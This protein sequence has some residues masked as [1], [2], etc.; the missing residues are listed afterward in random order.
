MRILDYYPIALPYVLLSSECISSTNPSAYYPLLSLLTD[1]TRLPS[2]GL[3][4][5]ESTYSFALQTAVDAG[6]L[7]AHARGLVEANMAL[8][9]AAPRIE[10]FYQ[11]Y[12]SLYGGGKGMA[13]K[14]G[15]ESW[16]EWY[17]EVLCGYDE[18]VRAV[19]HE[20]IEGG[21][22]SAQ[23]SYVVWSDMGEVV[24]TEH[25]NGRRPKSVPFDHIHPLPSPSSS[26][27]EHIAILYAQPSSDRTFH[28]L[29]TYLLGL[30]TSP[31]PRIQYIFRPVPPKERDTAK[32]SYLSGYGVGLD[33]KKMEYLAIDDRRGSGQGLVCRGLSACSVY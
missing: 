24:F 2:S 7:D 9:A 12:G 27:P 19:G 13:G 29:H 31:N 8:H 16:V 18:V 6:L 1:P 20:T 23:H 30:A 32:K 4:T 11:L 21:G 14:E 33:L 3:A 10:A 15:C 25:V 26:R 5:A 22:V 17:G 28:E